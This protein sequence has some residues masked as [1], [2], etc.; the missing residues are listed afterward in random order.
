MVDA[1]SNVYVAGIT[2]STNFPVMAP[3]QANWA[4]GSDVFVVKLDPTCAKMLQ[5]SYLGG[6]DNESLLAMTMDSAGNVYVAGATASTNFPATAGAAQTRNGGGNSDAYIAKISFSN[7]LLVLTAAP[8]TLSFRGNTGA[9]LAHQAVVVTGAA[10]TAVAWKADVSATGGAWL[11][12]NPASG[13]G[14][15]TINVAV[16]T[17]GLAAGTYAGKITITNQVTGTAST[18]SVTVTLDKPADPG[19]QIPPAGIV[20][21]ASYQGGSVAPA[22]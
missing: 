15:A 20:S 11:T 6:A 7:Q 18:V 14:T 5:G 3:F 16:D 21:A 2:T 17:T 9:S 22:K 13:T 10:G 19:G 4:G 12:V 8:N 1:A